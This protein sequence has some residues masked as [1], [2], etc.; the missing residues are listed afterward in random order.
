MMNLNLQCYQDE[1]LYM[2]IR[3]NLHGWM[4]SMVYKRL[5]GVSPILFPCEDYAAFILSRRSSIEGIYFKVHTVPL[6]NIILSRTF[7]VSVWIKL[8]TV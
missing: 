8:V 1:G 7:L 6:T 4:G 3:Q 5:K 2:L